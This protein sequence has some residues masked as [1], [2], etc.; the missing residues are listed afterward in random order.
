MLPYGLKLV[1]FALSLAGL[2]SS[3]V[4]LPAFP[5]TIA[6]DAW[7]P[8]VYGCVGTVLQ[9]MFCLGLIW[10][11]DPFL[12]PK[13]FCI[14]QTS[15][16]QL[17]WS[18]L[19]GCCLAMSLASAAEV[20]RGR[21]LARLLHRLTSRVHQI[22]L[23]AFFSAA[24]FTAQLALLFK[25]DAAQPID[26]LNCDA[27]S[28]SWVRLVGYSGTSL[29]LAVPS[30]ILS[31]M[32]VIHILCPRHVQS[33]TTA[34]A[35]TAYSHDAL[36]SLPTRRT[37]HREPKYEPRQTDSFDYAL[38]EPPI[39]THSALHLPKTLFPSDY[40]EGPYPPLSP[41]RVPSQA[42]HSKFHLPF[43]N[44][45][46]SP[47]GRASTP[48]SPQPSLRSLR[49]SPVREV[50]RS[51]HSSYRSAPSPIIFAPA[52]RTANAP[53]E[54]TVV[55]ISPSPAPAFDDEKDDGSITEVHHD[56]DGDNLG[57]LRW[58]HDTEHAAL[59]KDR[60][61]G[62]GPGFD[63]DAGDDTEPVFRPFPRIRRSPSGQPP[64]LDDAPA[65]YPPPLRGACFALF[66]GGALV[67]CA[68]TSLVDIARG[69]SPTPFGTQHA[70]LVLVAWAPALFVGTLML[71]NHL[72]WVLCAARP[73]PALALC[74]R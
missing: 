66:L 44:P 18:C 23:V 7:F 69:A 67:V 20:F 28:P 12:M 25:L 36:T 34:M 17:C 35:R 31:L 74:R 47:S 54:P 55:N 5:K 8:I 50:D 37:R 45:S 48:S 40:F 24:V 22:A 62:L 70:A 52:P 3:W 43:T 58:P 26:G 68:V 15:L 73:W 10:K 16:M 53:R 65:P 9:G 30:V 41:G 56:A 19:A 14:A 27:S 33:M 61:L 39:A 32:T 64:W 42:K 59:K 2:L 49:D 1:W 46:I 13:A 51:R 71:V 57:A 72:D 11:M 21:R 63:S 6:K 38:T 29:L 4:A 60:V